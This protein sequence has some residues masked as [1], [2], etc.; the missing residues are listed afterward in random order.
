M[1]GKRCDE[2]RG[3][4]TDVA[5]VAE[6]QAWLKATQQPQLGLVVDAQRQS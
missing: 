3:G 5:P 6:V 4:A 1:L 2:A